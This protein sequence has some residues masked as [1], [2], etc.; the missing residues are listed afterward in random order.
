MTIGGIGDCEA[1]CHQVLTGSVLLVKSS[2][3]WM[4]D[5][6]RAGFFPGVT[7]TFHLDSI[8]P[9]KLY[10]FARVVKLKTSPGPQL[11]PYHSKTIPLMSCV[12]WTFSIMPNRMKP[13]PCPNF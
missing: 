10:V 2:N 12:H 8:S 13:N 4:L 7:K 1:S 3:F 6:E 5:V 11:P 9:T